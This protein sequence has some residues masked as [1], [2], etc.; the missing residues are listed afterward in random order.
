MVFVA[1]WHYAI[2]DIITP[3]GGR[4]NTNCLSLC[5]TRPNAQSQSLVPNVGAL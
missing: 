4:Q 3:G 2:Y 5:H 1:Q